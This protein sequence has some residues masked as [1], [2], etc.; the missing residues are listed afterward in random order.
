IPGLVY[1]GRNFERRVFPADGGAGG[2]DFLVAQRGAVN[3]VA[4]LHVGSA[5]ADHSAAADQGRLVGLLGLGDGRIDR[6][7]VVAVHSP[8]HVPAIGFEAL[9]RV[10]A[11]PAFDLAVDG[12]AVVIVQNDQAGQAQRA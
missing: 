1:V 9:G 11:E 12:D 10:I 4:A 5:L 3:L 2:G 7:H 6:I 8:D